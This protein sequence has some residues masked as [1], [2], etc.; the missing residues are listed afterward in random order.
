MP[1]NVLIGCR[2]YLFAEGIKSILEDINEVSIVGVAHHAD[3]LRKMMRYNPDIIVADYEVCNEILT[4]FSIP[5]E[6]KILLINDKADNL[7]DFRNLQEMVSKGLAGIMPIGSDATLLKK[8][9]FKLHSG[10]LWIDHKTMSKA[11]SSRDDKKRT[12]NLTKKETEVLKFICEGY[13][14]KKIAHE[15]CVSEQTVKSHCNHL[16]KKFG[17]SN[18]LKL[19]LFASKGNR[20]ANNL[21]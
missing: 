2:V 21:P 18:R 9:I 16:F 4:N 19:A 13:S 6:L 20:F 5:K 10:E 15:L 7:L 3:D 17:V 1:I 14:N 11:L 8:A 12:V